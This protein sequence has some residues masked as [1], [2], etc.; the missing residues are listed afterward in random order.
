M[1]QRTFQLPD[2]GEGLTE[3]ELLEWLVA[4]GDEVRSGQAIARVE[5]DKAEVDVTSPW[6]GM[7]VRLHREVGE[8]LRTG[9]P[10]VELELP[11]SHERP[12]RLES[13][14]E[15]ENQEPPADAGTLV[16]KLP[17]PSIQEPTSTTRLAPTPEPS[18]R[19]PIAA[20]SPRAAPAA[21]ARARDLGLVLDAIRG[22]GPDG[23]ITR[24]DVERAAANSEARDS[25]AGEPLR[26]VRLAMARN[27]ARSNAAVAAAT[28]MDE[29]D[30][31]AWWTA[32]ID[33]MPRL[34]RAIV[35]AS[36][37]EPALNA[38]LDEEHMSRVLHA[39]VDLA[40]AIQ[41]PDGLFA[42]VLRDV[43]HADAETLSA[44]IDHLVTATHER[45][46]APSDLRGATIT[47]SNFGP[48]GGRHAALVIVPPQVAI[49]GTG[50]IEPT[51]VARD[52]VPA[53]RSML[54]LSLSFDHRVVTGAEA[55]GFL[56]A[57]R[58][59]LERPN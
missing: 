50:R 1:T 19:P 12:R 56:G 59:D 33:V 11:E 6:A 28:I 27:M 45:S 4:V 18:G 51:V 23:V 17:L 57:L 13:P 40:I 26:G 31:D 49:L 38:W 22:T 44:A 58:A 7:I 47:L 41:S 3:A 42:P 32:E 14:H 55:A 36:A 53:V 2:L 30:V 29:A 21:R 52:G 9:E 15:G 48:L 46:L 43:E 5:T 20:A 25:A 54:P 39:Q 24:V 37:A 34:V 8:I 35:A 10:L 16:G